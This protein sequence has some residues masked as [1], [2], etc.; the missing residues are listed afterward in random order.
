MGSPAYLPVTCHLFAATLLF[1]IAIDPRGLP[2][3][4]R[5]HRRPVRPRCNRPIRPHGHRSIRPDRR[6]ASF[7]R[8]RSARRYTRRS[9]RLYPRRF[10][11]PHHL[12]SRWFHRCRSGW[13]RYCRSVRLHYPRSVRLRRRSTRFPSPAVRRLPNGRRRPRH[14][15]PCRRRRFQLLVNRRAP[16]EKPPAT[17]TVADA[18]QQKQQQDQQE[19]TP[20]VPLPTPRLLLVQKSFHGRP[21]FAAV[22]KGHLHQLFSPE[23]FMLV[24]CHQVFDSIRLMIILSC[25]LASFKCHLL[26]P[27]F[28]FSIEAISR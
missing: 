12:R 5:R 1:C 23:I 24:A 13:F 11:R 18:D 14:N 7:R 16:A 8:C 20:P 15:T 21:G 28:I 4:H 25:R 27:S 6:P 19:P 2:L 3:H 22:R 9:F 10:A 17:G 26:V